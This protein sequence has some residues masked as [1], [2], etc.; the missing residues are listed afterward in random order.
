MDTNKYADTI[1][2][3]IVPVLPKNFRKGTKLKT[4]K[5]LFANIIFSND[6]KNR[7]YL[8]AHKTNYAIEKNNYTLPE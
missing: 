4:T 8:R 3:K 6:D 5:T 1:I 7:R 2:F